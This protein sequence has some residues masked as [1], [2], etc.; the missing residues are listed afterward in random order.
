MSGT[1]QVYKQIEARIKHGP[2]KDPYKP[3]TSTATDTNQ[4][5]G[6]FGW[7]RKEFFDAERLCRELYFHGGSRAQFVSAR[8]K[9]QS[10]HTRGAI[11]ARMDNAP[12]MYQ[13]YIF[14]G[15]SLIN[16]CTDQIQANSFGPTGPPWEATGS[17]EDGGRPLS[18]QEA[19]NL[20]VFVE[21]RN[22]FLAVEKEYQALERRGNGTVREYEEIM[23]QF[24]LRMIWTDEVEGAVGAA[25]LRP[26]MVLH[27]VYMSLLE[28]QIK[29][30]NS[31]P[32]SPTS[33]NAPNAQWELQC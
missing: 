2:G 27:K 5:E 8:D 32:G 26:Y 24:R 15:G 25:P 33:T 10:L 6:R 30:L 16:F 22:R 31:K 12:Y 9:I 21:W 19:A 4:V 3:A 23:Q 18:D 1:N 29:A 13:P 28:E 17:K 11:Y 14:M 20:P 7:W